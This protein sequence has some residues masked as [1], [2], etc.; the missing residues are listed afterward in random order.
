MR[1]PEYIFRLDLVAPMQKSIVLFNY[2]FSCFN[3]KSNDIRYILKIK[4][5]ETRDSSILLKE[6][7]NI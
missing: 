7:F 6:K 3:T 2:T 4:L 1:S 5:V